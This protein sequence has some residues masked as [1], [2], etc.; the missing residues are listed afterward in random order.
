[1]SDQQD[2]SRSEQ[3]TPYKLAKARERGAIARGMD[4]S[5]LTSVA[6]FTAFAWIEGPGVR[7]GIARLAGRAIA[8][9]PNLLANPDTL[10]SSSGALLLAAARPVGFMAAVIFLAVL[11]MELVQTGVV[12]STEPMRP[13]FNRLNPANNFK[14]LFSL[15]L[16]IEIA[17]NIAKLAIYV[18]IAWTVISD[19]RRTGPAVITDASHLADALVRTGMK[20]ILLFLGAAL[21][22]A[23]ID[24]LIAR[25][26][27]MRRMKMSRREVK[28]ELRDREGDPRLKQR[29]RQLHRELVKMSQS[30]RN[31]RGADV[32][33]TNPLHLAV[34]LRYD[35]KTMIAPTV[36]ARGAHQFAQRL[37][38]L[39]FVYGVVIVEDRALARG[40]F[41]RTDLDMSVPEEFYRPVADI[42]LR[43]RAQKQAA[44]EPPAQQPP[45]QQPPAR[46]PA[47]A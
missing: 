20:L 34:A 32:L 11:V 14:R 4:L 15:R 17:K 9:A 19:A 31:V 7:T 28:R 24:Q 40:L 25:R 6:A 41:R 29:R 1:M 42:Y 16:L 36:V 23:A 37:K 46:E 26:D 33:V 5:F 22:F 27:F 38:R 30:L 8:G 3:A 18:F 45:A 2:Q 39:A 35:P 21:V 47:D 13:D 12:F 44:Q 43:L 10:L